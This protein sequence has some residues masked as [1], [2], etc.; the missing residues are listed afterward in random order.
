MDAH[1]P[2]NLERCPPTVLRIVFMDLGQGSCYCHMRCYGHLSIGSIG[3]CWHLLACRDVRSKAIDI[4]RHA[5]GICLL[6]SVGMLA[7]KLLT[8]V[9]ML[10]S[11]WDLLIGMQYDL[12]NDVRPTKARWNANLHAIQK[13][14][15][16]ALYSCW[17]PII[18]PGCARLTVILHVCSC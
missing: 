10:G 17:P 5:L 14:L 11:C 4:S 3:I 15:H 8:S 18:F 6:A 7:Q 13:N 2:L 12:A 1:C 9:D 16:A